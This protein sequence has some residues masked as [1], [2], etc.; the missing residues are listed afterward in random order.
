MRNS[1]PLW[2]D[3]I[4]QFSPQG[5]DGDDAIDAEIYFVNL[6]TSA[7]IGP[8]VFKNSVCP[9]ADIETVMRRFRIE[10]LRLIRHRA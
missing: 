9:D 10:R 6:L 3:M 2:D 1:F 7:I 5:L 8:R 4:A